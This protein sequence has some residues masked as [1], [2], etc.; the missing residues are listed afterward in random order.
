M[1][2][3]PSRRLA[4]AS[5][6]PTPRNAFPPF[7]KA[8]G[9]ILA[10]LLLADGLAPAPLWGETVAFEL[11]PQQTTVT[12]TLGAFLHTVHGS[13]KLKRGA[14]RFDTE[15]G[16]ASG[17]IVVDLTSGVTGNTS[18]DRKMH[19]EVL[20]SQRYPEAVFSPERVEGHPSLQGESRAELHGRMEIHGAKQELV[21]HVRAQSKEG[22]ATA[23]AAFDVPYVK[24]GMKDPSTALLR[25]KDTVAVEVRT[26][27][28]PPGTPGTP[29]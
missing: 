15:T 21:V 29:G 24:W 20:E 10:L 11:D 4:F 6:R 7:R 22:R 5:L 27:A 8:L 26:V 14:I 23:T 18:R 3:F 25:V 1:K 28:G 2:S 12:F 9:R 16:Q 13:F 19:E 17:E